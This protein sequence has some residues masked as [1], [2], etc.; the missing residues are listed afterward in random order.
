MKKTP[1]SD[2][3]LSRDVGAV[4]VTSSDESV[5]L[6]RSQEK[7]YMILVYSMSLRS[8]IPFCDLGLIPKQVLDGSGQPMSSQLFSALHLIR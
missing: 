7:H 2:I 4:P 6:S 8:H 3:E 5:S 1:S